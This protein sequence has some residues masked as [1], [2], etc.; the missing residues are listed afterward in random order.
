VASV[1]QGASA[2]EVCVQEAFVQEAFVQEAFVQ[3][4]FVQEAFVQGVFALEVFA[5]EW[6][7]VLLVGLRK[8]PRKQLVL[9]PGIRCG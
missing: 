8:H 7:I 6:Q 4:A 1:G 9:A 2:R 5:Q 3:E